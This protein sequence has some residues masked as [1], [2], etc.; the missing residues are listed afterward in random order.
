[1]KG[2]LLDCC[3][4]AAC[5]FFFFIPLLSWG[6]AQQEKRGEGRGGKSVVIIK[7]E[8]ILD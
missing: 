1:M 7:G 5:I 2:G 6:H 8:R 4:V 3:F